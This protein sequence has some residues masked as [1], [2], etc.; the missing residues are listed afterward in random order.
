MK[1]FMI[2][3]SYIIG[4]IACGVVSIIV[5]DKS[6]N[7]I[8]NKIDDRV[9]SEIVNNSKPITISFNKIGY[10][11][12]EK[13]MTYISS[14]QGM[15][16]SI[17]NVNA[18]GGASISTYHNAIDFACPDKTPVYAVNSGYVNTVYPSYYNG[19]AKYKG[20]PT[21]GGL[22][23]IK[24]PDGTT[25]LYAHLSMT[26]VLEGNYVDK[27]DCIGWSGGVRNRRG[28]GNSTGSHLHFAMYV[29]I[30]SMFE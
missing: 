20:H 9:Q 10:P 23:E 24:H 26:K 22:V 19:G 6:A 13:Y 28:S 14:P 29:N 16:R 2:I 21:Y 1:K 3:F 17:P 7:F 11:L 25:S 8:Q 30:E 27:G 18:G 12:P 5:L 15:R 4:T